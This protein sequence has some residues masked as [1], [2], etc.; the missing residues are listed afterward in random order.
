MAATY[1]GVIIGAGVMGATAALQLAHAG[2]GRLLVLEKA[3]GVGFGS[4]GKSSAIFRQTYS[5][6]ETC[7]MAHESLA[8][9]T[10]SGPES[11]VTS[12]RKTKH[13]ICR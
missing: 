9:I 7:L 3:P 2:L 13:F 10:V 1:D 4:T 5:H 12:S 8:G 11:S 6:Y